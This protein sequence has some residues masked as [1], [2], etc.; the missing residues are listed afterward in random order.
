MER[1]NITMGRL[2]F[3]HANY[4]DLAPAFAAV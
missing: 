1:V 2:R 4:D 3:D